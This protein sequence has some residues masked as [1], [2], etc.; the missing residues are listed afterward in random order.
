M[1]E[2]QGRGDQAMPAAY[3]GYDIAMTF[4]SGV[5]TERSRLPLREHSRK[6]AGSD[7]T[8]THLKRCNDLVESLSLAA[9]YDAVQ[10]CP[11]LVYVPCI[12]HIG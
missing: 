3:A 10:P 7:K 5:H 11:D 4:R 8:Q 12:Q 2:V 9:C 1:V 6:G